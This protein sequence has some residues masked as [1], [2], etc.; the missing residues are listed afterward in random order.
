MTPE[1]QKSLAQPLDFEKCIRLADSQY[2]GMVYLL[3]P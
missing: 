1:G 3:I 2:N